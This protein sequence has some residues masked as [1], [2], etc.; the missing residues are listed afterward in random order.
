MLRYCGLALLGLAVFFAEEGIAK[1][2]TDLTAGEAWGLSG[3]LFILGVAVLYFPKWWPALRTNKSIRPSPSETK[4]SGPNWTMPELV[5]H[6]RSMGIDVVPGIRQIEDKARLGQLEFWGRKYS[7]ASPNENP[8][9]RK[10]IPPDHWDHYCLDA[11]RCAY[12]EDTSTCCTEPR[13]PNDLEHN[14][15]GTFQDLRVNRSQS[16]ALWPSSEGEK[17]ETDA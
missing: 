16:M 6:V 4:E 11:T 5:Q 7:A 1:M 14:W 3:A 10:P 13:S 2:I 15:T 12:A 8:N 9:P 17:H